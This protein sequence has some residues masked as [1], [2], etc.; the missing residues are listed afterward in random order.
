MDRRARTPGLA[1]A[2][3]AALA[4]PSALPGQSR[5]EDRIRRELIR[6]EA[7]ERAGQLSRALAGIDSLL[8]AAP[9]NPGVVLLGE[10]IYR[11]V[12]RLEEF[13]GRVQRAV[14]LQPRAVVLRQVQLRVLVELGRL[15]A[16][17]EAG[18]A[19]LTAT[20][21]DA[22]AYREFA[23]ALVRLGERDEADRVLRLGLGTVDSPVVLSVELADLYIAG[24]RWDQAAA[25]WIAMLDASS[26]F[27]PELISRR[28]ERLATGATE[29]SIA[30]VKG[31]RGASEPE[32]QEVLAIAAL[33]AGESQLAR[34][35]AEKAL[36][37]RAIRRGDAFVGRFARV[38]VSRGQPGLAAWAYRRLLSEL[39]DDA[40]RLDLAQQVV[41]YDL[42][43]ADTSEALS[44]L[45]EFLDRAEPRT[46][47]HRWANAE[48]TRLLAA[49]G[50]TGEAF[51]LLERHRRLYANDPQLAEL[52]LAVA[53]AD[54][55]RG[56]LEEASRV[57]ELVPSTSGDPSVAGRLSAIRGGMALYAGDFEAAREELEAAVSVSTGEERGAALR[58]LRFLREAHEDELRAVA[59]AQRRA[60]RG[61]HLRAAEGL[62][63]D[64]AG[65]RRSAARPGLLLW[66]GELA[67]E[68]DALELAETVLAAIPERYPESGEAPVALMRHGEVLADAGRT[69]EALAL[70]ERL[71]IDYPASA[72]TP[73]ARRRLAE[74][75]ERVPRS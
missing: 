42:S 38:A 31:L 14:N 48:R 35:A 39:E 53:E 70:L 75:Q 45:E 25:Q 60:S 26:G 58:L 50:A 44:V 69:D 19:W 7:F 59:R 67:L 11:R 24:N 10:R 5:G 63:D 15:D 28:L 12:G 8:D 56:R 55:S 3:L 29:L 47:G 51:R 52:A 36:E 46:P 41:R 43:A 54:L 27:G 68:G 13:A 74:L 62:I 57:L 32:A 6:L 22:T 4:A 65:A 72:L 1:L 23:A 40:L 17:H 37:A 21:G 71:I 33:Y 16:F 49:R 30:L 61:E 34:D 64:L 2:L 18:E 20:P 73:I 9:T 66:A